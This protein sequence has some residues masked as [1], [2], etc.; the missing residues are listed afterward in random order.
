M[1]TIVSFLKRIRRF[2]ALPPDLIATYTTYFL[3][4]L[5][6]SQ[7]ENCNVKPY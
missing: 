7:F 1:S 3:Y 6:M 5:T 2:K 4:I